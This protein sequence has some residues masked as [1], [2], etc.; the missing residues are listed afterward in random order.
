VAGPPI[1]AQTICGV[2]SVCGPHDVRRG[3][4]PARR[5]P[6]LLS[7]SARQTVLPR[8]LPSPDVRHREP[9]LR[10]LAWRTT[11]PPRA[12]PL[13]VGPPRARQSAGYDPRLSSHEPLIARA[14]GVFGDPLSALELRLLGGVGRAEAFGQIGCSHAGASVLTL[15]SRS[16]Q[17]VR[18]RSPGAPQCGD[19]R[20]GPTSGSQAC[21]ILDWTATTP[22]RLGAARYSSSDGGG[23]CRDLSSDRN[24]SG[25]DSVDGGT[26]V[27]FSRAARLRPFR[28]TFFR[29]AVLRA[30]VL[31]VVVL[32]PAVFLRVAAFRPVVFRAAVLRAAVLR[33]TVL[34]AAVLRV[35]LL[36][37]AVLRPAVLGAAVLRVAIL[38][39][40]DLRPAV[41]R[42]ADLRG[43]VFR[44]PVLRGRPGLRL[45]GMTPSVMLFGSVSQ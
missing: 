9:Q 18:P 17:P 37:A 44:A 13:L 2:F 42:A 6:P 16:T 36:R 25:V 11:R 32:R 27:P 15:C 7:S 26:G 28:T 19:R 41:L 35:V 24:S 45:L 39:T 5:F 1:A 10:Q 20:A 38:R 3:S 4:P 31:R 34:R 23:S 22:A 21:T 30:A 43:V 40:V 8:P 29:A 33:P 12:L 14:F